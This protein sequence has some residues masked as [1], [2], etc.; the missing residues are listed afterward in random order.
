MK[1]KNTPTNDCK[2]RHNNWLFLLLVSVI[3]VFLAVFW[4]IHSPQTIGKVVAADSAS[5]LPGQISQPPESPRKDGLAL[6][7]PHPPGP[8]TALLATP[9]PIDLLPAPDL[10][11]PPFSPL[12]LDLSAGQAPPP[13]H[14]MPG[15]A[16]VMSGNSAESMESFCGPWHTFNGN[17]CWSIANQTPSTC[18]VDVNK[19]ALAINLVYPQYRLEVLNQSAF[20]VIWHKPWVWSLGQWQKTDWGRPFPQIASNHN[21]GPYVLPGVPLIFRQLHYQP[22]NITGGPVNG[23]VMSMASFP[24]PRSGATWIAFERH[25]TLYQN[26]MGDPPINL[27]S[28]VT[29]NNGSTLCGYDPTSTQSTTTLDG[30]GSLVFSPSTPPGDG[31]YPTYTFL[32]LVVR[33]AGSGVAPTPAPTA[34]PYVPVPPT[35][36][37]PSMTGN[38]QN[39]DFEAGPHVGWSESSSQGYPVVMPGPKGF[40]ARS[41]QYLAWLGGA[42]NDVSTISQALT[43]PVSHPYLSLYVMATSQEDLC[44]YDRAAIYVNEFQMASIGL[45]KP[46]NFHSWLRHQIDLTDFAGQTVTFTIKVETDDSLLSSLFVDDL[47]FESGVLIPTPVPSPTPIPSDGTIRNPGF[48]LGNNGDWA[49]STTS[50][51]GNIFLHTGAHSGNWLAWLGGMHNEVGYIEQTVYIP[52]DRPYL[53]YW[54]WISSAEASCGGDYVWFFAG[55]AALYGY[56]LCTPYNSS[57][58]GQGWVNFSAYAGTT[59]RI[60]IQVQTNSALLSSLYLDDFAFAASPPT[61]LTSESGAQPFR[62]D[63]TPNAAAETPSVNQSPALELEVKEPMR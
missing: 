28:Y 55:S 46:Q 11:V 45:C 8:N 35:P 62:L 58:W 36:S 49:T 57:S 27:R 19:P 54:G 59:Q 52:P 22:S 12:N 13:P 43:V 5:P 7:T 47:S 26:L 9:T 51:V 1:M 41:G 37:S 63:M 15:A 48:E 23:P 50:G 24:V 6:L 38:M 21:F 60:R 31:G 39:A 2:V 10:P 14:S 29:F 17:S 4:S 61:G 3:V 32:P 18:L 30:A 25:V 16:A 33:P 56:N 40:N 34:T 53:T 42:H 20:A 44:H